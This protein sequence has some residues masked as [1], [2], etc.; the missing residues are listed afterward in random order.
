MFEY[1]SC[2]C[3]RVKLQVVASSLMDRYANWCLLLSFSLIDVRDVAEQ[4]GIMIYIGTKIKV[5]FNGRVHRSTMSGVVIVEFAMIW[6]S[7]AA[8]YNS[9]LAKVIVTDC[10]IPLNHVDFVFCMRFDARMRQYCKIVQIFV[11]WRHVLA[12]PG[13]RNALCW[14]LWRK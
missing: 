10:M 6:R 2:V 3:L 1:W 13:T 14:R 4:V 9:I 8:A 7:C 12:F 5:S 11:R